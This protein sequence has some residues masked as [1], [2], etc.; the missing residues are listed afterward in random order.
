ML[1]LLI[2]D[3]YTI[4]APKHAQSSLSRYNG[5]EKEN[6]VAVIVLHKCGIERARIFELLKPLT[7]MRVFVYRTV[8]LF[9]DTGG[10]NDRKRFG[11][12]RMVHMLQVINVVR[13]RINQNP[14]RKQRI[15][16]REMD[17]GLRT[18]SRI[19]KEDLGLSNNKQDNALPLHQKKIGGK[20]SRYLLL[21]GKERYKEILFADGKISAV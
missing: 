17:M 14:V 4:Y 21:Y 16:A 6:R 20:K 9:L 5:V 8:K 13:P 7:I 15:M 2:F 10:L 11:W 1:T 19:I 12:P 3:M 18:M